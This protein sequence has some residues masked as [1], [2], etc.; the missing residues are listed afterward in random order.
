MFDLL[1]TMPAFTAGINLLIHRSL[2]RTKP[3]A[4]TKLVRL[5]TERRS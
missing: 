4:Q 1:L 5:R 3:V 2:K